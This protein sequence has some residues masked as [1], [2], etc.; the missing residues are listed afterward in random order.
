[1]TGLTV[2]FGSKQRHTK[3]THIQYYPDMFVH[4][5]GGLSRINTRPYDASY[6]YVASEI[7]REQRRQ[8]QKSNRSNEIYQIASL[9][10]Y[11]SVVK[12]VEGKQFKFV[13]PP[14][15]SYHESV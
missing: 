1:M 15:P 2:K 13:Q 14:P 5:N 8:R 11:R 6:Y 7:Q 10:S 3:P 12:D 9:P 4:I